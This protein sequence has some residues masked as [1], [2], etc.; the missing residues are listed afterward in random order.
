MTQVI[1]LISQRIQSNHAL[2]RL[3]SVERLSI[4]LMW[5]FTLSALIGMALGQVEWFIPKTP[6]NLLL[7]FL[8]LLINVPFGTRRGSLAFLISFIVGMGIEIAGVATGDIFGTYV[9][10]SNLGFKA[11]GV[12]LMIGIY[13]AVLVVVTSQMA[14]Q[15]FDNIVVASITGAS[16]MVGLDFL[17][18]QMASQFDFWHFEHA[19]APLQNY[20]AWFGVALVLQVISFI[21]TPKSDGIFSTQLYL[22]QV[23]FF[24]FSYVLL[25]L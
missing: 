15:V 20:I 4:M 21:A 25:R 5:L 22:N 23:V 1:K 6:F 13:W 2:V 10:G 18:E 24:A 14:R 16:L 19:I 9:Y 11:W 17:M 7:C 3:L 8:L 12:P